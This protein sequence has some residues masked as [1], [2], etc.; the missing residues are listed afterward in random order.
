MRTGSTVSLCTVSSSADCRL[1]K[2]ENAD[3]HPLELRSGA[4]V[5]C[6]VTGYKMSVS[7]RSP[8]IVPFPIILPDQKKVLQAS[9]ISKSHNQLKIDN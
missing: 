4:S 7:P 1:V 8:P 3:D 9:T 6:Y 2:V 5:K